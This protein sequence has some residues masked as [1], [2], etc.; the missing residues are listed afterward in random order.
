MR[1]P[2][3]IRPWLSAP[4]LQGWV[5]AAPTKAIYQRRLV[6]WLTATHRLH[7]G[8]IS[9]MVQVGGRSVRRWIQVYNERGPQALDED[10]RGGRR[11]AY[12]SEQDERRLLRSLRRKAQGAQIL[13][14]EHVRP[15][16][17]AA[18][19]H[20]VSQAYL[21]ELTARHDWRKVVPR[22]RHKQADLIEQLAYKSGFPQL[23]P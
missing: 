4:E 1:P 18:V 11:W 12:L 6:I 7:A 19:G 17:E 16:V 3:E 23:A 8:E 2:A 5:R 15:A 10:D 21:Y 14:I 20:A 22:P 9:T 13:T